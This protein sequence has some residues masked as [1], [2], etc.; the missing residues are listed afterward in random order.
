M[1]DLSPKARALI[2]ASRPALRP[3]NADRERLEA[4]LR[5]KL[6]GEALPSDLASGAALW[7][8]VAAATI[9]V[10]L[11]GGIALRV[12]QP[13]P[14]QLAPSPPTAPQPEAAVEA[15]PTIDPQPTAAP[16]AL[17]PPPNAKPRASA[18]PRDQLA[19]EVALLSRATTALH[20][21]D[22]AAALETLEEHQRKFP[23]GSLREERSIA[24]AQALCSMGREREGR[25]ELERLPDNAPATIRARRS[26][27]L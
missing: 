16:V 10:C 23:H 5:A 4:A 7:K 17:P 18:A 20:A 19:R 14:P 3:T 22:A 8:L 21:G 6:G 13:D 27:G 24:K 12:L 1:S 9:S 11:L 26:C 25:A 15:A 2:A